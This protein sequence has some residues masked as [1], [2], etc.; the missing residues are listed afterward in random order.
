MTV[1]RVV[2]FTVSVTVTVAIGMVLMVGRRPGSSPRMVV[3]P[4]MVE[5]M[6]ISVGTTTGNEA[7]IVGRV[8]VGSA[9]LTVG[10]M[11][12]MPPFELLPLPPLA[13]AGEAAPVV[14]VFGLLADL[15]SLAVVVIVVVA[16][17]SAMTVTVAPAPIPAPTPEHDSTKPST[18]Q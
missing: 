11:T 3:T 5:R 12:V 10:S 7:V 16:V 14:L 2:A 18:R 9:T 6:G 13:E 1:C 4:K 8:T 15:S 17:L